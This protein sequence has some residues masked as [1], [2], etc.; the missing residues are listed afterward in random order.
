MNISKNIP[1]FTSLKNGCT[2]SPGA[3]KSSPDV[4]CPALVQQGECWPNTAPC[5][6]REPDL[7]AKTD[8]LG[9]PFSQNAWAAAQQEGCLG[10]PDRYPK[11]P[12]P[13]LLPKLDIPH[14]TMALDIVDENPNFHLFETPFLQN[15]VEMGMAKQDPASSSSINSW[16]PSW[17]E[18]PPTQQPPPRKPQAQQPPPQQ[19]PLQNPQ[20]QQPPLQHPQ[21][22]QP[23]RM[24]PLQPHMYK[25]NSVVPDSMDFEE[26][27]YES[28]DDEIDGGNDNDDTGEGDA[29]DS[30]KKNNMKT[31]I[32][33]MV[34]SLKAIVYDL[35]H[36]ENLKNMSFVDKLSHIFMR[37]ERAMH[38]TIFVFICLVITL[39]INTLLKQS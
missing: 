39:L 15:S 3:P 31:K 36:W 24:T 19:L 30:V 35:K 25:N 2:R 21:A 16:V 18:K 27:G 23:P 26:D 22:Q 13:T 37:D 12:P 4:G 5:G 38:L 1:G 10:C 7:L 29:Y 28:G 8:L 20:A 32:K 33:L 11:W 17:P 34:N 14:Q 6:V 9:V